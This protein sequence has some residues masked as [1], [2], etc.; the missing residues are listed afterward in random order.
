MATDPSIEPYST[1]A[2]QRRA[3]LLGMWAFLATE[4]LFFG[5]PLLLY[6]SDRLA[7]G[8]AF[9]AGSLRLALPLGAT[10]TAVLLV[11]SLVM[12]LAVR[13][14]AEGRRRRSAFLLAATALLGL[15]FLG[16][17]M[18]EWRD[19]ASE[20]L[21]PGAGFTW[22]G[23]HPGPARLFF[24]LYFALTGLHAVHMLVGVGLLLLFAC[25]AFRNRPFN[26]HALTLLGLYWHFV[27]MVWIFL[28][29]LLYL[30]PR[31]G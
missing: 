4:V 19:V 25:A 13:A 28:F 24:A 21:W 18:H 12:V 8:A 30:A 15:V 22:E 14:G 20:G 29:P 27:D 1:P 6:A 7:Y 23:A 10:N 17:K 16:I 31:H 9:L 5:G 26:E 11:S 3:A 2:H